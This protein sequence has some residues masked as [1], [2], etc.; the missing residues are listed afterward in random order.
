[1]DLDPS[2]SINNMGNLR[3]DVLSAADLPPA[4]RN[5]KSDPYAKFEL[6]GQEVFKTKTVKKTLNPTWNEF[7]EIPVPSRTA[8]KFNCKVYDYDF[9]DKPDFL[10]GADINL[11]QLDPFKGKEVQLLLDGKSGSVKLRLL[12][13]PEYI[14]RSRMGTGTFSGTFAVPGRIVTGV[15]GA[16]IKGVGAVGHGVGKGA[17]FIKRGIR[18][19]KEDDSNG[20]VLAPS[21]S[22][23]PTIVTNGPD[24]PAAAP[25]LRRST[26][27]TTDGEGEAAPNGQRT[28][29]TPHGRTASSGG[30][31]I[32][33]M[34]PGGP[35]SGTAT[36]QVISASGFPPSS[37]V[38]VLVRQLTPKDKV[39][40]KTKHHEAGSGRTVKFDETFKVTCSA[41]TQ[42]RIEA[43]D[44]HTFGSDDDLGE[45]LYFVDESGGG[46]K[47]IKVGAGSVIIKSSFAEVG[48]DSP[49][50]SNIRRSF[51]SK[52]E[53][54]QSMSREGTPS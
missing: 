10:G 12:F 5:G 31:S 8:A 24:A 51:L 39:I 29:R 3:V 14:T 33:S 25:G 27:L 2:E 40:G 17:S 52:R 1:M 48:T 28:P 46:E 9:A 19:K 11:E 49:K 45:A 18:G 21:T 36:F 23:L 22:D 54:R 13:K 6:N 47:E 30:T 35:G 4:D 26:G 20:S 16:P 37:D 50:S 34:T 43:K 53:P 38:Y 15:V 32:H 41:D 44:H 7:F 42:F